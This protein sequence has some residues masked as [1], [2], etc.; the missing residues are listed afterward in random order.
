VGLI[1]IFLALWLWIFAF[2]FADQ[3]CSFPLARLDTSSVYIPHIQKNEQ[4]QRNGDISIEEVELCVQIEAADREQ[5]LCLD[6]L[7]VIWNVATAT[8]PSSNEATANNGSGHGP[9]EMSRLMDRSNS[10]SSLLK[11]LTYERQLCRL[12]RN[13]PNTTIVDAD[14]FPPGYGQALGTA[15]L[16]NTVVQVLDLE[17]LPAF[18]PVNVGNSSS[19]SSSTSDRAHLLEFLR[20][21]TSL[22]NLRVVKVE[23]RALHCQTLGFYTLMQCPFSKLYPKMYQLRN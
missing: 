22:V 11:R 17:L 9:T 16:K 3:H 20:S 23:Y 6:R 5:N 14:S 8:T 10:L 15:L 18:S 4:E 2:S 19:S 7:A 12:K 1:H 13:D 21:T